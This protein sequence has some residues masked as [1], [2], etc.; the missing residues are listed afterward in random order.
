[1]TAEPLPSVA[2]PS[3]LTDALRRCG[4]LPQGTVRDVVV[5]GS[6][7]KLRS[8]NVR[9]RLSYDGAPDGAPPSIFLKTGHLGGARANIGQAEVR[10]YTEV[11]PAVPAGLLPRCY[12]AS[13]EER[14]GEWY[15]L[16]EDLGASH[17]LATEWPL[18]PT[19]GQCENIIDALARFH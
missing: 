1:M 17:R 9:L 4:A 18:P 19:L 6:L 12:A 7:S 16:L 13:R 10:F 15:L 11:A 3:H 8:R 14:T 2:S 5:D